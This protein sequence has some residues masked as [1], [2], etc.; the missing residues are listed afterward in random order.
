MRTVLHTTSA[1]A[2]WLPLLADVTVPARAKYAVVKL[3]RPYAG[4]CQW[5]QVSFERIKEG[6]NPSTGNLVDHFDGQHLDDNRWFQ[7]AIS[8]GI[9]PRVHDRGLIY[10]N[11]AMYPLTSY[12]TFNKLLDY[13]GRDHYRLQLHVAR[14]GDPAAT[15]TLDFAVQ[16]NA[17][18]IQT[19][20]SG[21]Y[22]THS[23]P[24]AG[25]PASLFCYAA[26]DKQN[27]YGVSHELK[28][29]GDAVDNVWY[30]FDFDRQ[31]VTVYAAAGGYDVSDAARVAH[32]P[33]GI[34]NLQSMG[35]VYFKIL[36]H[37]CRIEE[38][39][40]TS[41]A[42][43]EATTSPTRKPADSDEDKRKLAIPGVSN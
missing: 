31:F 38:I 32:F 12:A 9:S 42:K 34:N 6:V 11:D 43:P 7:S 15:S 40:L 2:G 18:P 23:F 5:D 33:H 1:Q 20:I 24:T 28:Q 10:D 25:K 4:T 26:Q 8:G 21:M 16:A 39:S 14:V 37:S 35:D 29:L 19:S 3:R 17:R 22:W 41:S 30:T 13:D 36:G 27:T